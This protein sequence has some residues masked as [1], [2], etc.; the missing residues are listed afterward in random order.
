[1]PVLLE[2]RQQVVFGNAADLRPSLVEPLGE[3]WTKERVVLRIDHEDWNLRRAAEL[4]GRRHQVIGPAVVVRLPVEMAPA[5]A[6]EVDASAH[7]R[8]ILAGE[9]QGVPAA[10]GLS[11]HDGAVPEY[12]RLCRHVVDGALNIRRPSPPSFEKIRGRAIRLVFEEDASSLD[13]AG[14]LWRGHHEALFHKPEGRRLEFQEGKVLPLY[15][16]LRGPV[17]HHHQRKWAFA[18]W[19][20][21]CG[22]HEHA[23]IS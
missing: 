15:G 10:S 22:P 11:N 1:M 17:I 2:R 18:A 14:T 21:H 4:A 6:F 8:G 12:E 19:P 9:R 7:L 3:R 20:E 16:V 13:I 23:R 5:S